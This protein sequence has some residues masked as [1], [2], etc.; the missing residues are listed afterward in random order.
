MQMP[1]E[2]TPPRAPIERKRGL[3]PA[4]WLFW[5]VFAASGISAAAAIHVNGL[6][7]PDPAPVGNYEIRLVT[8]RPPPPPVVEP[9]PIVVR[10]V[11]DVVLGS[12][13]PRYRLPGDGDKK[14]IAAL[15]HTLND[16]DVV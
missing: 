10:A 6:P 9:P 11:G 15:H 16:A 13:Y 1:V 2:Q 3:H 8:R 5:A 7:L 12:N 4:R 14:R